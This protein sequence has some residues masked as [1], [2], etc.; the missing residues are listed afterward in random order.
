[1]SFVGAETRNNGWSKLEW[2]GGE[3]SG[4]I[5]DLSA[6]SAGMYPAMQPQE[7]GLGARWTTTIRVLYRY[8]AG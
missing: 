5:N 8:G 1:M 7:P 3:A 2:E 6:L 4:D